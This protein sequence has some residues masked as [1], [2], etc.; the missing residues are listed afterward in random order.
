LRA[1]DFAQPGGPQIPLGAVGDFPAAFLDGD[2]GLV[3][4][5]GDTIAITD[6]VVSVRAATLTAA[7]VAGNLA[8][9]D[10]AAGTL[11]TSD[12]SNGGVDS[13]DLANL[14]VSAI[15]DGSLRARNFGATAGPS[16]FLV[17][18]PGCAEPLNSV[19]EQST[20]T[21]T[22]SGTCSTVIGTN[23]VQGKLA[24]DAFVGARCLLTSKSQCPIPLLGRLVFP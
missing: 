13:S 7:H 10:L 23:V 3:F 8:S 20:C 16:L 4:S 12:F 21:F 6:G 1:T 14:P 18:E 9:A 19:I 2:D 17:N 22:N 15:A 24:C 11:G 5:A